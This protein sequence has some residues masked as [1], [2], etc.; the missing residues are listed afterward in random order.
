MLD[1]TDLKKNRIEDS[2]I[3]LYI[4]EFM[5]KGVNKNQCGKNKLFRSYWKNWCTVWERKFESFSYIFYEGVLHMNKRHNVTEENYKIN[6]RK[7]R[8]IP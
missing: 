3:Y 4:W 7:C 5:C 6:R 8:R 1:R 2:K